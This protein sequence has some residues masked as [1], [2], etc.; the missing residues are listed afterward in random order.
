M[1]QRMAN[2]EDQE[3]YSEHA[4]RFLRVNILAQIK[5]DLNCIVYGCSNDFVNVGACSSKKHDE[6]Q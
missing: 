1:D 6:G 3:K 4:D 5:L 2:Y